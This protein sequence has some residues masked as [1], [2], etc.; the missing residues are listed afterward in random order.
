MTWDRL[1]SFAPDREPARQSTG[2]TPMFRNRFDL[3]ARFHADGSPGGDGG[4]GGNSDAEEA[5]Q[6]RLER[7]NQDGVALA[8]QLWREVYDYR[9]EL[10]AAKNEVATLQGKAAPEGA[11]ILTGDDAAAWE[12]YTTLG[13]PDEVKQGLDQRAEYAQRLEGLARETLLRQ[14]AEQ[15]GYKPSVLAQL[16]RMAKA[17]GR[18]LAFELREV[19]QDGQTVPTPFVKDGEAETPLADYAAQEWADFLPA[20]AAGQGAP[21]SVTPP[22]P[23][24]RYPPQHP[25]GN[26]G[27]KPKSVAEQFEQEQAEKAKAVK[28]PLLSS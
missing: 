12:A 3:F 14:V 20:L 6:R 8:R 21:P 4:S 10:R 7:N 2:G 22:P 5:F 26:N 18:E 13:A 9:Q 1:F 28:N 27:A 24:V 17:Q 25:G 19:Q 23:G 15:A 11:I 16:D